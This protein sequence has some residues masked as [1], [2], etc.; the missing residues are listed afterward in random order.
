[1]G[2][3]TFTTGSIPDLGGKVFIVTGGNSGVGYETA[4]QLALHNG[5]VIIATHA[6]DVNAPMPADEVDGLG[7]VRTL[8][9]TAAARTGCA[10]TPM[11]CSRAECPACVCAVPWARSR[12]RSLMLLW[13]T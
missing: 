3:L 4:L 8:A 1:M 5:H 2:S 9:T 11:H 10:L 7:S 13:N 12:R 6:Q